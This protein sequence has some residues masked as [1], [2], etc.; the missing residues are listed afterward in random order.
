MRRPQDG[1]KTRWSTTIPYLDRVRSPLRW[2]YF[3]Y[4]PTE[5]SDNEQTWSNSTWPRR[6]ALATGPGGIAVRPVGAQRLQP[7]PPP[8]QIGAVNPAV[9]PLVYWGLTFL[10]GVGSGLV[11]S[12]IATPGSPPVSSVF[13][14]VYACAGSRCHDPPPQEGVPPTQVITATAGPITGPKGAESFAQLRVS[15]PAPGNNSV[16]RADKTG[17]YVNPVRNA[18]GQI[19]EGG[20]IGFL[21]RTDGNV[22]INEIAVPPAAGLV[23]AQ[24][25]AVATLQASL[26]HVGQFDD[27]TGGEELMSAD[28]FIALSALGS[29]A[30]SGGVT[31]RAT[32]NA[33]EIVGVRG[34]LSAGDV[35]ITGRQFSIVRDF[36]VPFDATL[37]VPYRVISGVSGVLQVTP[38]P[39]PQSLVLVGAGLGAL[40]GYARR[41]TRRV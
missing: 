26:H 3:T 10:V 33:V 21:G 20:E 39:E 19:I 37:G 11:A 25:T 31:L 23:G 8:P 41:R 35:V 14:D 2:L 6:R 4:H 7:S 36:S 15:N 28:F 30:L 27:F 22:V 13:A 9:A 40:A 38:V 5:D 34:M 16:G 1:G 24:Q 17:S 29:N 18:R 32:P 12:W